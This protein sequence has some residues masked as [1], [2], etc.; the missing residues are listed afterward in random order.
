MPKR[1]EIVVSPEAERNIEEDEGD[2]V[3]R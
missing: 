1:F 3:K 2:E